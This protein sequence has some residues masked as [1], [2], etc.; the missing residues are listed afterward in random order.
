MEKLF[1]SIFLSSCKNVLHNKGTLIL[2]VFFICLLSFLGSERA[3]DRLEFERPK[4]YFISSCVIMS[5]VLSEVCCFLKILINSFHSSYKYSSLIV[6]ILCSLILLE[7][8]S[9]FRLLKIT[10]SIFRCCCSRLIRF[11]LS[12]LP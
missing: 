3:L 4:I 5:L 2:I 9:N 7:S 1:S 8:V 10:R 12:V 6:D 11:F